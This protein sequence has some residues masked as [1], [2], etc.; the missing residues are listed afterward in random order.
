MEIKNFG[1]QVHQLKSSFDKSNG[2]LGQEVSTLAHEKNDIRKG[3]DELTLQQSLNMQ[4]MESTLEVSIASGNNSLSLLLK[5]AIDQ[6]NG[7]LEPVLGVSLK[8]ASDSGLD[9]TPEATADRIVSLSTKFFSAYQE[10]HPEMDLETAV[11]E[12][13]NLIKGGIEKGFEEAR[14]VLG[15]LGVLEGDIAANIDKTYALVQE[16]LQSFVAEVTAT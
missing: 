16:K 12:F 10:R 8:E 15:G 13:T 9:V 2:P 1:N 6:L 14:A 11:N 5:T 4:I 3:V 7:I